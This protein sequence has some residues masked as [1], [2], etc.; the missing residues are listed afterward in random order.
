MITYARLEI[1]YR[2]VRAGVKNPVVAAYP[3]ETPHLYWHISNPKDVPEGLGAGLISY[4]PDDQFCRFI[5]AARVEA[6]L[7][8][9]A[10]L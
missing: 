1:K 7:K 9:E 5:P 10:S 4:N 8:L 3:I 6:A 2:H